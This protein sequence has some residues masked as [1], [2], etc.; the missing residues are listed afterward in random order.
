MNIWGWVRR[1]N[2]AVYV[3]CHAPARFGLLLCP[4]SLPAPNGAVPATGYEAPDPLYYRNKGDLF[5]KSE[6]I[7][8]NRVDT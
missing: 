4:R 1:A 6:K 3:C 7:K 5:G 8:S 2:W